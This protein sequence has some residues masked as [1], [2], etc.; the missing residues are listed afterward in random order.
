M[1]KYYK[2][3]LKY[4]N[5]EMICIKVPFTKN[6]YREIITDKIIYPQNKN[7]TTKL[8]YDY[9]PN[10]L[11]RCYE[12]SNSHA[13]EWLCTLNTEDYIHKLEQM[14]TIIRKNCKIVIDEKTIYKSI[15]KEAGKTIKKRLREIR[16]K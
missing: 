11:P 6:L 13:T 12:I 8:T 2:V 1:A 4:E 5:F 16:T 14:E 7:T 10:G 15:E 3:Y 9:L